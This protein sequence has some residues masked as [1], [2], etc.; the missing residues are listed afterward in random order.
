MTMLA[1]AFAVMLQD[2]VDNPEFKGLS[3]IHI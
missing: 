1:F 3:L 2:Q